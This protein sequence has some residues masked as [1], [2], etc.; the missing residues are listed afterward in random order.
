MNHSKKKPN[1][2]P[3]IEVLDGIPKI[4][5]YTKKKIE[6]GDEL[7]FNY[8][9]TRSEVLKLNPWLAV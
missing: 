6:P 5:L 2:L 1:L 8:G 4:I 9:E 3:K 7:C